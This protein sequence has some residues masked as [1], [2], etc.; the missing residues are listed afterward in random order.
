MGLVVV[1]NGA[2]RCALP[3]INVKNW[4]SQVATIRSEGVGQSV[5][6]AD[7]VVSM[8]IADNQWKRDFANALRKAVISED[9]PGIDDPR[10]VT[11]SF[12]GGRAIQ[13][14]MLLVIE[15]AGLFV[16]PDRVK[17]VRDLL[18]YALKEC[19]KVWNE[20]LGCEVLIHRFDPN[21]DSYAR[22]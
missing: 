21:E 1:N 12:D 22:G 5:P 11:V 2:R 8:F 15:V 4:P 7:T 19:G 3:I 18:A 17:K 6:S 16:R 9:I 20:T 10:L 13:E 14:D